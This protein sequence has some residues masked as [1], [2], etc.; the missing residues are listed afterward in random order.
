MTLSRD[1]RTQIRAGNITARDLL[2]LPPSSSLTRITAGELIG[3]SLIANPP[4]DRQQNVHDPLSNYAVAILKRN[5]LN[6]GTPISQIDEKAREFL[7]GDLMSRA[8]RPGHPDTARGS[9]QP[10]PQ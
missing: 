3:L 10:D 5:A 6:H 9:V 2:K 4:M 8:P 7:T 1:L